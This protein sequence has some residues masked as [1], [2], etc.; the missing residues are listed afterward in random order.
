[1]QYTNIYRLDSQNTKP[2]YFVGTQAT[3]ESSLRNTEK[4][5][6]S[7]LNFTTN[8]GLGFWMALDWALVLVP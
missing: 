7:H 8:G 2:I 4:D 5:L 6:V 3:L 1:M